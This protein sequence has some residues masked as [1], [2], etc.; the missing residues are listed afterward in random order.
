MAEVWIA[1]LRPTA[2]HDVDEL[3]AIPAGLDVW[4]RGTDHLVAAATEQQLAEL[5]RRRLAVVERIAPRAQYVTGTEDP[6]P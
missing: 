6:H 2:G 5:E 4:E 3:L 1:R